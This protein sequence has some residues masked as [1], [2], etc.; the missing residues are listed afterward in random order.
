MFDYSMIENIFETNSAEATSYLNINSCLYSLLVE[1]LPAYLI[2]KTNF[3]HNYSISIRLMQYPHIA[4][5]VI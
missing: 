5:S 1:I 4:G 2:T 3:T